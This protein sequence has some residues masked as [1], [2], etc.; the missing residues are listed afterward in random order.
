MSFLLF[1]IIVNENNFYS[2]PWAVVDWTINKDSI[3]EYTFLKEQTV[4]SQI[5]HLELKY[6]VSVEDNITR[7]VT[8]VKVTFCCL[9]D[10]M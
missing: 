4:L 10:L 3:V 5:F 7:S 8:D 2:H 6:Y 1:P 9:C